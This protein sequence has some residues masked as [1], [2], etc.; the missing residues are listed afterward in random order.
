MAKQ[1][2]IFDND[3]IERTRKSAREKKNTEEESWAYDAIETLDTSGGI[4][5]SSLR[6]WFNEFP[7][8]SK[9]K[10]A[11]AKRLESTKNDQH[12][13]GVNEL[14]WWAFLRK[15]QFHVDPI[16]TA[17]TPT[18][19][20]RINASCELF[21]EVTTLN[22][23]KPDQGNLDA[24][25]TIALDHGDTLFRICRKVVDE[26]MK[27]LTYAADKQKP[28]VLVLFDYT[29]WSAFGTQLYRF[30]ADYLLGEQSGFKSLPMELSALIYVERKC[31]NGHIG[32]N[33]LH[34]AVYYNPNAKYAIQ[35]GTFSSLNQF[36]CQMV[37][38][39]AKSTESWIWL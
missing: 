23:S 8:S 18:P 36:W 14:A 4:Y 1:T 29:P 6:L 31:V 19:D 28:C 24:A 38:T 39:E 9:Q 33:R 22:V 3:W 11:L 34:S 5:L 26:K 21:A 37:S 35:V 17:T 20:F 25:N 27:Q 15:E 12:L 10:N 7:L 32:I 30:L 13:G 16:P 2:T